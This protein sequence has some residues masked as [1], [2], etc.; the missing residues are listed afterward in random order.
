MKCFFYFQANVKS[1]CANNLFQILDKR[2]GHD[3]YSNQYACDGMRVRRLQN[4]AV[5]GVYNYDL[6]PG[7]L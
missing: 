6:N 4:K 7:F 5:F 3:I 1:L 2:I